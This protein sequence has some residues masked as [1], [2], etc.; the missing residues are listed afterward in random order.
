MAIGGGV[1]VHTALVQSD[2]IFEANVE[3]LTQEEITVG[4]LCMSCPNYACTS[5]GV[6]Y[7][8]HYPA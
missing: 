2:P 6:V 1:F 8:E 4:N 7:L 3:A 5:L